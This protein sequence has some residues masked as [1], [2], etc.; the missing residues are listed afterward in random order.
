MRRASEPS[1]TARHAHLHYVHDGEPGLRREGGKRA[2]RYVDAHGRPVRDASTLAR[3]R[4]L[5]IPPAW[6]SVWIC[7]S[8]NGHI[9]ATGRDARGRKQYRYHPR[10][11]AVRD[12]TKYEQLASFGAALPALRRRIAMDRMRPTLDRE[13]VLATVVELMVR[14]AVRV[15]NERYARDNHSFGLTTLRN[16]H[17]EV[18]GADVRFRFV[19]KSG[20]AHRIA[21]HDARLAAV[22]K[23]CRDLPGQHLFQ[24]LDADDRPHVVTSTDVNAYLH[25]AT[26]LPAISAKMLRTW[27]AS[28]M[29]ASLLA[30]AAPCASMRASRAATMRCLEEVAAR[31]GN[32]PAIARKSYV[33]PRIVEDFAA[34]TFQARM[35]RALARTH[36]T[37]W[38]SHEEL[39]LL[40][41]LAHGTAATRSAA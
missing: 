9:Q 2:F 37:R 29:A 27:V 6:R 16:R 38:M 10:F 30:K 25:E 8:P 23:R 12:E 35:R 1:E 3:I 4:A 34:G 36:A 5:A 32:T 33:H 18:R 19:G 39:A 13:K 41:L 17:V 15:G 26:G 11:R 40:D 7:P 31:L 28:V 21:V 24:W 22:V 14:S 20:K